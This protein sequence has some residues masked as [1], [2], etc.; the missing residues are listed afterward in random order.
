MRK[1]QKLVLGAVIGTATSGFLAVL[2]A[3]YLR[4][5]QQDIPVPIPGSATMVRYKAADIPGP[6]FAEW[7]RF[8]VPLED[9][10]LAAELIL[11]DSSPQGLIHHDRISSTSPEENVYGPWWF[12]P[13][14]IRNGTVYYLREQRPF[15]PTVW[16]DGDNGNVYWTMSD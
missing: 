13:H 11:K 12:K 2:L 7:G 10:K 6:G 14:R 1:K 8:K 4:P 15:L 5:F 16:I 3:I 9:C